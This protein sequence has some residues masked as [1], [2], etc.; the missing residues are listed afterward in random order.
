MNI[1]RT[2]ILSLLALLALPAQA[3]APAP[4]AASS[5]AGATGK[6]LATVDAGGMPIELTFDLK[7]EGEKLT[8]TLSVMGNATP[9]SEGKV[10]AEEV[11]F[12][13]N[14]DTGMGGPPL[15]ITYKGKLKGDELTMQSSFSMG[16]GAPPMVTDF[17]AKRGK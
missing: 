16:E 1:L 13:V 6:W 7:A 9:I 11:S 10:K 2:A 8:G 15:L 17:V 14:F 3:A 5:P 4:A 12:Q